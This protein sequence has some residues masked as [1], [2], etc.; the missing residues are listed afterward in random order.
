MELPT[1]KLGQWANFH[2]SLTSVT[3]RRTH[4]P[5]TTRFEL[6]HFSSP[7][8]ELQH[9]T[10]RRHQRLKR[11]SQRYAGRGPNVAVRRSRA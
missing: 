1:P 10:N 7:S 9:D 5:F 11:H 2:R 8:A 6:L 4:V 3:G